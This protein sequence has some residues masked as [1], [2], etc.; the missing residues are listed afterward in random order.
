MFILYL[1]SIEQ[2]PRQ[3]VKSADKVPGVPELV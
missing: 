1:K 2:M 3:D